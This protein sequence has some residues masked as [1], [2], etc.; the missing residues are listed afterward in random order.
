MD[1]RTRLSSSPNILLGKP[2]IKNTRIPVELILERLADGMSMDEI[3][4]ASPGI[5]KEDIL[6]CI[7]YSSEVISR[8]T[9]K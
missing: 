6:A 5:Q 4:E 2:V 3:L 7:S 9:L 1:Y 8:E